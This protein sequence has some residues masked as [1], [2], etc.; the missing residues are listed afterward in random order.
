VPAAFASLLAHG[1]DTPGYLA[2][3]AILMPASNAP[4]MMCRFAISNRV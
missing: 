1:R 3:V 4:A 2:T